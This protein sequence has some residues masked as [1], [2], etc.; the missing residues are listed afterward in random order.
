M[1]KQPTIG[2]IGVGGIAS[3]LVRGICTG[4][5]ETPVVLS[6]RNANRAAALA[7]QFTD[8]V[9]VARD[10]QE[11]VDTT[12]WV[13]VSVLPGQGEAVLRPL[14]FRPEQKVVSVITGKP[15][16]LV[17]SWIGGP[18]AKILCITPLPC[19]EHRVGP[20][21][22]HPRNPEAEALFAPLG[23][24]V[25]VDSEWEA[26]VLRAIAG[27]VA[28]TYALIDRIVGWSV[29][30]GIPELSAK[31][32]TASLI[33]GLCESAI[34]APEGGLKHLI[35]DNTPGGYN[36]MTVRLLTEADAFNL[37]AGSLDAILERQ[38]NPNRD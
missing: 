34:R 12:D 25:A 17:S 36:E 29:D 6:P 10:N 26:E 11:V 16:S 31:A 1:S 19:V 8:Q 3:A 20:I 14:R 15:L 38:K 4:G 23:E 5:M 37:W 21:I 32:Y 7:A 33:S 2:F 35:A 13:F 9:R 27:L 24:I 30:Q 22:L 18:V 28:S